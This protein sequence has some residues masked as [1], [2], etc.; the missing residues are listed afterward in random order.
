[1]RDDDEVNEDANHN[2]LSS[3]H[4]MADV[5]MAKDILHDCVLHVENEVHLDSDIDHFVCK[6]LAV[7]VDCWLF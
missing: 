4:E 6:L 1:M 7:V 2:V 3:H 5:L